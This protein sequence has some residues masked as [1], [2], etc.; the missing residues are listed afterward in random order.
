MERVVSDWE[1]ANQFARLD[2][3]SISNGSALSMKVLHLINTLSTGG[4]EMHL[5]TLCRY[6]KRQNVEI[7]VACLREYVKESRSLR[8]DFEKEGIK[9]ITLNADSR[10]DYHFFGKIA[11][12]LTEECPDVLHTHLPRADLAGAFAGFLNPSVAWVSSVHAI[13]SE[14]WSGRWTLPLIKRLWRRA[15][16][17]LCISHAVKDWLTQQ[18]MPS[19]KARV[20]HYGIETE[21]FSQPSSRFREEFNLNGHTV[22]GSIGRL[23]PRKNHECLI[24][25]M[26]QVCKSVPNALLLIA[27][28]DPWGYGETLRRLIDQLGLEA[29]VRLVG[30]QHDVPSFLAAIDV[31]AFATKSEGFGQVLVEAMAAGKPVVASR[32]SPLTEIVVDGE[33]GLLV[34]PSKPKAFADTLSRLLSH[35][36]EQRR[37]GS[38]GQERVC[39]H[40]SAQR[41]S[42]ET[43]SL[44]HA[45]LDRRQLKAQSP[46]VKA[47]VQSDERHDHQS[48]C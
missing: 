20:I 6:L 2:P 10:Y 18:G 35:P 11:R 34:E 4:A 19:E 22:I 28:H 46:A 25:A 37:M 43:L 14:D 42:I 30:F 3:S 26:P 21:P 5:L 9:I 36:E 41:M 27:G 7:V 48:L 39:S 1:C 16:A 45:L 23:E 8:V 15:D 40:F 29:N 44:Y 38:L 47:S 17:I 24:T 32:I 12:V 33:T 31:F 13:Y